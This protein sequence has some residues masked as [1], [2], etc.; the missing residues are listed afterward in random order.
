MREQYWKTA[1]RLFLFY[2]SD[3]SNL[4]VTYIT[5]VNDT[6]GSDGGSVTGPEKIKKDS[7]L[8]FRGGI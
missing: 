5:K 4:N 6:P 2:E 7:D 8:T 1:E 3:S